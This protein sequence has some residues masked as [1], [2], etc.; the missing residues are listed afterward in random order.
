AYTYA[1]SN[2]QVTQD[3]TNLTAGIYS[4]LVTDKNGCTTTAS[5]TLTQPVALS[6]TITSATF[7]GSN[8][9]CFGSSNGSIDLTVAGG[10]T[11]YTYAWSN[12]QVTQDITNLTAGTYSVLVTDKNGCTATN[13]ITLTQPAALTTTATPATFNGSNVSCFGSS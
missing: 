3:I 2:A 7:N 11:A 9:S 10:T 1:W 5:V 8:V 13:I 6:T 4:V 12:A